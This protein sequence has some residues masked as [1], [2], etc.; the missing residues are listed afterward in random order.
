MLLDTGSVIEVLNANSHVL[1]NNTP[2]VCS[3]WAA[4][5]L[6]G[7]YS[8]RGYPITIDAWMKCIRT[9]V[10]KARTT[11]KLSIVYGLMLMVNGGLVK[12]KNKI[13][14]TSACGRNSRWARFCYR[15]SQNPL[16]KW[17]CDIYHRISPEHQNFPNLSFFGAFISQNNDQGSH[18]CR[19]GQLDVLLGWF[20]TLALALETGSWGDPN[21]P[22]NSA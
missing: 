22:C 18:T 15:K 1:Q 10:W 17:T 13:D 16:E 11:A 20:L 14:G 3:P 5:W 8:E 7:K 9:G 21:P 6:G 19:G 2:K 4:Q 12:N